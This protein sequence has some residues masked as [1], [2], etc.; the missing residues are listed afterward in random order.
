[1]DAPLHCCCACKQLKPL[2]EFKIH[3]KDDQDGRQGDPTTKCASCT[4]QNPKSH[5]NIKHKREPEE[6]TPLY[7]NNSVLPVNQDQFLSI[8]KNQ[9][10]DGSLPCSTCVTTEGMVG[11][12]KGI[13]K[14]I[15]EHVWEATSY[16]FT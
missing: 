13:A 4:L 16:R 9:A 6:P 8:L 10:P 5:Q 12:T 1:M 14:L 2:N 11:D 15:V 3:V 7:T